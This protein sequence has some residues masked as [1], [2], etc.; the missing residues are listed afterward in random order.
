M[1]AVLTEAKLLSAPWD[2]VL[3]LAPSLLL[4]PSF[5]AMLVCANAV[6]PRDRKIWSQL[7]VAF[8]GVYVPLCSAAYI[9]ELFVVEPRILRGA[10]AET[11]LLTIVRGDSV[12]NAID[13]LGYIFM[14]LAA[15]FT[16]PAFGGSRLERWIRWLF[17]AHGAVALPIFLTY[18][19]SRTFIYGA[20]LWSVTLSASG[21]LMAV[22]FQ[23]FAGGS[24]GESP[25]MSARPTG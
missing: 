2:A 17:V 8:A 10:A 11:T 19:V 16:A 21:V 23:R 3:P 20:A 25:S 7:G 18:F 13:G 5:L 1:A 6:V 14:S 4:A 15:L 9:V 12:F 24:D 22:F